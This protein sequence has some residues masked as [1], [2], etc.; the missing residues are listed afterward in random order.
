MRPSSP[1]LADAFTDGANSQEMDVIRIGLTSTNML[2]FASGKLN[3]PGIMFTASHNPAQ[4]NGMKLCKSGAVPIAF[5]ESHL[6]KL[7]DSLKKV[8]QS[9]IIHR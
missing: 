2:Y 7:E 5:R 1:L 3:L 8:R 4:Y 9:Q 6:C